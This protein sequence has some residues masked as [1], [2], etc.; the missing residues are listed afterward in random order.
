MF[1]FVAYAVL[2][3]YWCVRWRRHWLSALATLGGVAGV[4]AVGFFHYRL[5]IWTHGKIFLPVLQSILYPYGVM[6]FVVS[7][8]I[9]CLPVA[10]PKV[11]CRRCF[12]DL[13][14]LEEELPTCPECGLAKAPRVERRRIA[15]G[16]EEVAA[17]AA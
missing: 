2:I 3:W 16:R 12:Y 10:R 11:H 17:P 8:Y 7:V 4:V 6:L 14:G 9:S 1:F 15:A 13:A 5:N